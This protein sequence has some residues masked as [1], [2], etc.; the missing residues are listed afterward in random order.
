MLQPELL[1][2]VL[3]LLN[4]NQIDYM[5]TG[6]LVSSIQGELKAT[7]DVDIL[8]NINQAAIPAL[9]NAFMPP[10]YYISQ[11]AIDDAIQHKTMFNL[12]DT[13]E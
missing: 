4:E 7:N 5:L 3:T 2:K 13:N 10:D 1:I 9:I 6:S 12:L 11:S 8:A